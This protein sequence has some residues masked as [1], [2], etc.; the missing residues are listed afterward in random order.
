MS[1]LSNRTQLV[2]FWLLFMVFLFLG[3]DNSKNQGVT[4]MKKIEGS[5]WYRERMLPP[6]DAMVIVT[7]ED[8]AKM[9][10]A[11]ELR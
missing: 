10:V 9:D 11:S 7:L 4:S 8:V 1:R 6:P 2:I 3:T 5:V